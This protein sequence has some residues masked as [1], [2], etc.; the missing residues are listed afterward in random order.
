MQVWKQTFWRSTS[1]MRGVL[2]A[3]VMGHGTR[4]EGK[5]EGQSPSK[6]ATSLSLGINSVSIVQSTAETDLM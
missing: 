5:E 2:Q 3:A 1:S 4:N 6:N